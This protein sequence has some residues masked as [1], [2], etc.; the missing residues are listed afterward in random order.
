MIVFSLKSCVAN[1]AKNKQKSGSVSDDKPVANKR[2]K[3]A[4]ERPRSRPMIE[5]PKKLL[6]KSIEYLDSDAESMDSIPDSFGD[7]SHT[8]V[9]DTKEEDNT[10]LVSVILEGLESNTERLSIEL[11]VLL[12][13]I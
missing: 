1:G 5:S 2:T 11:D 6:K 7:Q 13:S 8:G 9:N 10:E 12:K 3:A 4:E